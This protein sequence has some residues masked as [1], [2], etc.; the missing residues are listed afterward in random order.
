MRWPV[1]IQLLLLMLGVVGLGIV[2]TT[3]TSAYLAV[4]EASRY[5]AESL[6][7]VVRTLTA[8]NYPLSQPVLEHV[9]GLS[10]AQ[11]VVL[12]GRNRVLYTT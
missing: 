6:D 8:A 1:R 7:R 3:L 2:L 9:S 12:D 10:G 4:R 5:Q 11:F